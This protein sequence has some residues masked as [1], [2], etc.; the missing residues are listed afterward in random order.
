MSHL[1]KI[2]SVF[3]KTKLKEIHLISMALGLVLFTIVLGFL[4]DYLNTK[5][6]SYLYLLQKANQE[7]SYSHVWLDEFLNGSNYTVNQNNLALLNINKAKQELKDV[8][9]FNKTKKLIKLL[10]EKQSK[11]L[12]KVVNKIDKLNSNANI[13]INTFIEKGVIP[14]IY[15]NHDQEFNTLKININQ[16]Y[17]DIQTKLDNKVNFIRGLQ[18][19]LLSI[20]LVHII[21]TTLVIKNIR[22]KLYEKKNRLKKAQEIAKLGFYTFNFSTKKWTVSKIILNLIGYP[23]DKAIYNSWLSIIHP[24]DKIIVLKAFKQKQKPFDLI[25]RIYS[26]KDGSLHWIH[27]IG[28]FFKEDLKMGNTIFLGTIQDITE[29][30][31]LELDFINAFIDAQEQEKIN[32]GEDLHDGIGQILAA[33]TMYIE[34]LQKLNKSD[35]E[36]V[37][38][39]ITKIKEHNLNAI[40]DARNIAH[41]LM[42]KILKEKGLIKAIELICSDYNHSKNISFNFTTTDLKEKDIS[43]EMKINLFRITQEITTNIVRHS[44][45]KKASISLSKTKNNNLRLLIRDNGVGIDLEK[46]KREKKG[47][48]LNN[49]ERRVTLLNGKLILNTV[50]NEGTNYSITVPLKILQ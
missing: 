23:N 22:F 46:M 11:Q 10:N 33:E 37:L 3:Y 44:G 48:G 26:N 34:V 43:K 4:N 36:R 29:K 16:A 15:N 13:C 47:A 7:L 24:D 2:L 18:Y 27:H 28:N 32:F 35:D 19:F 49:I 20:L 45:A 42:S 1:S 9:S 41:G 50:L 40:T 38:E 6:R 17:K 39:A 30:R 25:Y 8:L 5:H 21:L 14:N 31:K 12:F